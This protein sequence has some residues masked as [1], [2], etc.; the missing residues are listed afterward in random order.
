MRTLFAVLIGV[1]LLSATTWH[2]ERTSPQVA[3]DTV[4]L[5]EVRRGSE[6]G[7]VAELAVSRETVF[8]E[9]PV[10]ANQH[11]KSTVFVLDKDGVLLRVPVSYGRASAAL[12]QIVSG[13]SPGD[14]IIVS[15]MQG[16]DAFNRLRLKL[17]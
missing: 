13:V 5:R 17:R 8:V 9:R 11:S 7:L 14:R 2:P 15:D 3:A 10:G 4:T 12:I 1:V 6:L 16:W